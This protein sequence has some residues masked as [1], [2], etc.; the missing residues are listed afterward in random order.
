MA[1]SGVEAKQEFDITNIK[2]GSWRKKKK[3]TKNN[4]EVIKDINKTGI[5]NWQQK[6]KIENNAQEQR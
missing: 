2:M 6:L 1:R 4:I 5:H 3:K